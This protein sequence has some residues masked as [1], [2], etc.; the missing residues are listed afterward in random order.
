MK[1]NIIVLLLVASLF[2]LT[3]WGAGG[4]VPKTAPDFT[5]KTL[6]GKSVSLSDYRGK[7]VFLNF[8][9]S[10]CPPC[11][12]EMPSME[13]LNEVFGKKDFVILAVNVEKGPDT[14]R[15][16]LKDYPYTFA[17]LL[18]PEATAQE[19][20]GVYRFPESFLIDKSGRIVH[21]F[22]GAQDY[23]RVDFL[24]SLSE[25]VNE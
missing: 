1:R 6:D 23:S 2:P 13:R 25:Y 24:Q 9:A 4:A 17:V 20:F 7:V 11:R 15:A 5:L 16:F 18:D 10:W 19:V 3:A 8:W 12:Q 14:V 21:K 22:V